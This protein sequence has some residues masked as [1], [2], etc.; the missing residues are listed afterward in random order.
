M[1]SGSI[2][3]ANAI[4]EK[5][6]IITNAK[7]AAAEAAVS[8][9][10]RCPV[11]ASASAMLSDSKFAELAHQPDN[12]ACSRSDVASATADVVDREAAGRHLCQAPRPPDGMTPKARP[13]K[14]MSE[15]RT[16]IEIARAADLQ[17]IAEV[18]A[19]LGIPADG[20]VASTARTR[21]R[22]ASTT[23][24]AWPSG[25]TPSWCWSPR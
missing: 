15:I 24:R 8:F 11:D 4:I 16:D 9:E 7:S 19:R 6:G 13:G 23:S 3:E 20:A 18:A 10:A 12:I 1:R 21:P 2:A 17:P 25:R 5:F 14:P 22:S